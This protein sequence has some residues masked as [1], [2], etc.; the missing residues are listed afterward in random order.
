MFMSLK[1]EF[2][3]M[4][5]TIYYY[6]ELLQQVDYY[7]QFSYIDAI[8][9]VARHAHQDAKEYCKALLHGTEKCITHKEYKA[10]LLFL[11]K[12]TQYA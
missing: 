6:N 8:D 9:T 5:G 11:K 12:H 4:Y 3:I 10:I 7:S 2:I 1:K